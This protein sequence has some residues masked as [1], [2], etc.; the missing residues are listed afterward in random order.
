VSPSRVKKSYVYFIDSTADKLDDF[1]KR[2]MVSGDL[3]VA[4]ESE[5]A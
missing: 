4:T 3:V 5:T 1:I 2:S